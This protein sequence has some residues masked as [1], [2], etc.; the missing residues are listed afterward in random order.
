MARLFAVEGHRLKRFKVV[1]WIDEVS[2]V[3]ALRRGIRE[4]GLDEDLE[5]LMEGAGLDYKHR[6][7]IRNFL[8]GIEQD[9]GPIEKAAK[10]ID[11]LMSSCEEPAKPSAVDIIDDRINAL[12]ARRKRSQNSARL[13]YRDMIA[14]L[15]ATRAL[16]VEAQKED[17]DA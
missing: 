11:E 2:A 13:V 1:C 14:E 4:K 7:R 12:E 9:F 8:F 6:S 15:Q 3:V 10:Q 17:A 16:V 5:E